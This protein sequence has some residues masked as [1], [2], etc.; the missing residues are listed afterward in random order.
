LEIYLDKFDTQ[1]PLT[2]SLKSCLIAPYCGG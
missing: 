1:F 2:K